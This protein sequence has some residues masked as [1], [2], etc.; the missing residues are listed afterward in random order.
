[1]Y[2]MAAFHRLDAAAL[3][4]W[5]E[6]VA[7]PDDREAALR[8]TRALRDIDACGEDLAE[9]VEDESR[10]ATSAQLHFMG[11]ADVDLAALE[12]AIRTELGLELGRE[13]GAGRSDGAAAGALG[14]LPGEVLDVGR[15][16][17]WT[18]GIL[19]AFLRHQNHDEGVVNIV[20]ATEVTGAD[21]AECLEEDAKDRFTPAMKMGWLFESA[22]GSI[23]STQCQ[24]LLDAVTGTDAAAWDRERR[25][26][27]GGGGGGIGGGGGGG[28]VRGEGSSN[29]PNMLEAKSDSAAGA[30]GLRQAPLSGH[31]PLSGLDAAGVA[32][33]VERVVFPG[34]S[35]AAERVVRALG[36]NDVAG[37]D[38][39]E[40]VEDTARFSTQNQLMFLGVI[41]QGDNE[42]LRRAIITE[43]EGTRKESSSAAVYSS[44]ATAST[45]SSSAAAPVSDC[46]ETGPMVGTVACVF[47]GVATPLDRH[48][49]YVGG[50]AFY[51]GLPFWSGVVCGAAAATTLLLLLQRRSET[52]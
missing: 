19:V 17:A 46:G 45:A 21:F 24:Q 25:T 37:V 1:M 13:R 11:V 31:A 3:G 8:C 34:A 36:D 28:G 18:R 2:T 49:Q 39:V 15:L 48:P 42:A 10:L 7:F 35:E 22:G 4:P 51:T 47:D 32:R 30:G 9:A 40:A 26:H 14:G 27:D 38:L 5:L 12:R 20:L 16:G 29:G 44:S 23:N 50:G 52:S 41:D 6:R 33:W 43:V